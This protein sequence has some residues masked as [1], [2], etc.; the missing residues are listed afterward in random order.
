[1]KVITILTVLLFNLSAMAEFKSEDEISAIVTGGNTTSKSIFFGSKNSYKWDRNTIT[2]N[3]SSTYSK[4]DGEVDVDNWDAL[5]RYD[6]QITDRIDFFASYLHESDIFKDFWARRNYDIG[7]K[8]II[9]DRDK[10]KSS[11]ELGYR[12]TDLNPVKQPEL[13]GESKL[14]AYY[15]IQY[16]FTEKIWAQ[17][18]IEYIPSLE[19]SENYIVNMEPSTKIVINSIFSLKIAVLWNYENQPLPGNDQHDYKYTTSLIANF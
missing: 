1:M 6:R 19:N 10:L 17:Y 15:D 14:R 7:I 2:L 5:L 11:F 18:W 9:F 4:S 12:Y 13:D 16:N 8:Y 3:G